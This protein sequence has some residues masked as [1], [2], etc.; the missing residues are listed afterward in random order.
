MIA[1]PTPIAPPRRTP[2]AADKPPTID[3]QLPTTPD[4]RLIPRPGKI[5][6]R[7]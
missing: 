4:G 5:G 7:S 6:P 1:S 2:K 3:K